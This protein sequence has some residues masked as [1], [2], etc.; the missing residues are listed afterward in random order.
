MER[1][2]DAGG[3][4]G[5]VGKGFP[6]KLGQPGEHRLRIGHEFGEVDLEQLHA[7]ALGKHVAD[8]AAVVLL[9]LDQVRLLRAGLL[10]RRTR[11]SVATAP[12]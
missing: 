7:V 6:E 2:L 5:A 3:D 11:S 9:G 12:A 1:R 10:A 4:L 8:L